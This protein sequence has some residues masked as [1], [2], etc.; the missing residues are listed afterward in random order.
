MRIKY[1]E[2][3]LLGDKDGVI[4]KNNDNFVAVII[5]VDSLSRNRYVKYHQ[6][7]VDGIETFQDFIDTVMTDYSAKEHKE[8]EGNV[9]SVML[10]NGVES[11]TEFDE[12]TGK[13]WEEYE[14]SG[15]LVECHKTFD[16]EK[17]EEIVKN[18]DNKFKELSRDIISDHLDGEYE[19]REPYASR[20]LNP[21]DFH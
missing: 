7:G 12:D 2:G 6:K 10:E 8:E 4:E 19:R 1:S 20:G 11:Y 17:V 15:V 3:T 18:A 5:D 9:T 14:V 16:W 21:R 13:E